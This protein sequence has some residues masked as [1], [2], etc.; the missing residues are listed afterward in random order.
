MHLEVIKQ[1]SKAHAN[2]EIHVLINDE[3]AHIRSLLPERVRIHLFPRQHLQESIAGLDYHFVYAFDTLTELV[4]GLSELDLNRVVNLTHNRLSGFIIGMI[5]AQ[6]KIGL[7]YESGFKGIKDSPWFEYLN[8]KFSNQ[9]AV[10]F[11]YVEVLKKALGLKD[12]K[13]ILI[14]PFSNDS[15]KNWPLQN[16]IRIAEKLEGHSQVASLAFIGTESDFKAHDELKNYEKVSTSLVDLRNEIL[17]SDALICIDSSVK[18]LALS[19]GRP[20][21]EVAV[22]SAHPQKYFYGH[23]THKILQARTSCFPCQYSAP[24]SQLSL[25]Q[26]Y[27]CHQEVTPEAVVKAAQ[28]FLFNSDSGGV[29]GTKS[30]D[31]SA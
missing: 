7:Y 5:K 1:Y 21:L 27:I 16:F 24:C 26:S 11:S 15:K 31:L 6:D 4:G 3:Y 29:H 14:H 12:E 20:V 28:E 18:H 22:G 23:E 30:S 13:R 8:E 10:E 2:E 25:H 17:W 9:G 19:L